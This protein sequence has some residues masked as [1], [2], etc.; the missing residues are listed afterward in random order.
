[1][2]LRH[3]KRRPV[4]CRC[5]ESPT[6]E[7]P[8]CRLVHIHGNEQKERRKGN[9]VRNKPPKLTNPFMFTVNAHENERHGVIAV[10]MGL[11]EDAALLVALLALF[12][13]IS[14]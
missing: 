6:D 14:A 1:M 10:S 4:L 13:L 5:V 11:E 7:L 12:I 8:H 2:L 3:E 9:S